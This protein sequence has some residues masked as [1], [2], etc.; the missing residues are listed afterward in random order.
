[1]Q[2]IKL[3]LTYHIT[4]DLYGDSIIADCTYDEYINDGICDYTYNN[5]EACLFDGGDCCPGDYCVDPNYP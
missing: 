1:M 3:Q 5:N 4:F 2:F